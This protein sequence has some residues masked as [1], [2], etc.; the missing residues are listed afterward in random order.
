VLA[1]LGL[2]GGDELVDDRLGAVDE[3]A[4][5]GLPQVNEIFPPRVRRSWL[6]M[7]SRLSASSF[8]GTARTDVAVGTS[9]DASMFF[10]TA[11]AAPRSGVDLPCSA[12]AFG[13]AALEALP[14]AG[15]V[16]VATGARVASATV[17]SAVATFSAGAS[18]TGGPPN[19]GLV[20]RSATSP[21]PP[22]ATGW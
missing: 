4:E 9:S 5:L 13:R 7:T 6:L 19:R 14:E 3:V 12:T 8:A 1:P 11:D 20:R 15:R 21:V 10:T 16:G 17:E 2:A 22:T 18:G